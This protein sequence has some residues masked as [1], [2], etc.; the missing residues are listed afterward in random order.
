MVIFNHVLEMVQGFF[1]NEIVMVVA[2][3][4]V[5]TLMF[6]IPMVIITSVI[7]FVKVMIKSVS[8]KQLEQMRKIYRKNKL[9]E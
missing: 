5:L 8:R 6:L 9:N 4:V 2:S 1:E 3:V 7:S